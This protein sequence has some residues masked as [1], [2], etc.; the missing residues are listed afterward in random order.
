MTG[1]E[2]T[3]PSWAGPRLRVE[4]LVK[5]YRGSD[6]NAVDGVSL[7]V[8]A[9]EIFG[10]LGP[11]GAGKTSTILVST[12]RARPT[13][14]K[15]TLDGIDVAV[16][17][18]R[19]RRHLGVVTQVNTL[20]RSLSV[21]ENL[22]FHCRFF[23]FSRREAKA[24]CRD[25]LDRFE[26]ADRSGDRVDHLSGGLA[27]RAQLARA[28]A[29]HPSVLFLDEPTAWLDPQSRLALWDRV[30][31][32]RDQEGVS[33]VL[34]THS[35]DEADRLCDRVAI[36]DQG[37]ILV[38]GTPEELKRAV[39]AAVTVELRLKAPPSPEVLHRLEALRGVERVTS[40]A[41]K[42]EV[43]TASRDGAVPDLVSAVGEGLLDL[44]VSEP[45]LES[46]FISLTG[47]NL[48]D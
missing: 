10:L 42:V 38:C 33:V 29:H 34:T 1:P 37:R 5:R 45:T 15:V 41:D 25:L 18:S 35:M 39:A 30:R 11:N 14:G 23:G 20:D 36:M 4:G 6:R 21:W 22:Y 7:E 26:L 31:A 48:R 17:G 19:A 8:G 47:R 32:L 46:V 43:L 27:Q 3:A 9:G 28:L 44:S 13:A 16:H 12:T 2:K 24:R 40:E